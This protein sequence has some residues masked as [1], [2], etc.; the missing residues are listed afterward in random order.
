MGEL[1]L[2]P[3]CEDSV[4]RQLSASLEEG[5]HQKLILLDLDL[6]LPSLWNCKKIWLLC[7][8]D[9]P[10]KNIGVGCC[11]LLQGIFPTQ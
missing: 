5:P 11:A 4:R 8:W 6:E 1:P 3:C 10:G 9:F 2:P 7:P